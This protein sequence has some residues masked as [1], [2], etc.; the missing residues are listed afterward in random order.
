MRCLLAVLASF[1]L[2]DSVEAGL[3]GASNTQIEQEF[4]V[5]FQNGFEQQILLPM[6]YGGKVY[7][8]IVELRLS[9]AGDGI[10]LGRYGWTLNTL[11]F[12]Y[13]LYRLQIQIGDGPDAQ[14][15]DQDYTNNC[16]NP[17]VG[18]ARGSQLDLLPIRLSAH[19]DGSPLGLEHVR[20]RFWGK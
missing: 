1:L 6:V 17:P 4:T 8:S 9:N 10:L 18:L 15:I 16:A 2:A 14:Q 3:C 13:N 5:D 12:E 7:P 11:G 19:A 20:L